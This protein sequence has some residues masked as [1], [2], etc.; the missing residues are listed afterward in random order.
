[1]S[2]LGK[3]IKG[4]KE[5][6]ARISE[7]RDAAPDVIDDEEVFDADEWQRFTAMDVP[8]TVKE[9]YPNSRFRWLHPSVIGQ[10]GWRRWK[11][12]H[13]TGASDEINSSALEFQTQVDTVVR[14][15]DLIL[16][17]MPENLARARDAYYAKMNSPETL[18]R[19][20][21]E[22]L[23]EG[24]GEHGANVFGELKGGDERKKRKIY[25]M[26]K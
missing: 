13:I 25:D 8:N 17:F 16:A 19:K 3:M 12:V 14:R 4:E 20:T 18:R 10:R 26:G 7:V 11:T 5:P 22:E 2:N 15:G 24:M 21:K 9:K 1:M 23:T 6:A